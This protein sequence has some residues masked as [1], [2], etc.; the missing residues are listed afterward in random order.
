M[1]LNENHST[2]L[3]L[4]NDKRCMVSQPEIDITFRN[5][6]VGTQHLPSLAMRCS[7][8]SSS[9]EPLEPAHETAPHLTLSFTFAKFLCVHLGN[10]I[11]GHLRKLHSGQVLFLYRSKF[12]HQNAHCRAI[13]I[14]V[15][16]CTCHLEQSFTIKRVC[17]TSHKLFASRHHRLHFEPRRYT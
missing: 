10:N 16:D 1:R 3:S 8:S 12:V 7:S 2:V 4:N 11:A 9:L 5:C 13:W 17:R 6:V 14:T 15:R